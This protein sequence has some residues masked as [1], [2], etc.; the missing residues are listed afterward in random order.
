MT[1]SGDGGGDDSFKP[2][3]LL[4][5]FG[6]QRQTFFIVAARL[7]ARLPA[8]L[9]GRR[10]FFAREAASSAQSAPS[11]VARPVLAGRPLRASRAR[12]AK[13]KRPVGRLDSLCAQLAGGR[14]GQH[15]SR[16]HLAQ[17]CA[18]FGA[19]GFGC[20]RSS[21]RASASEYKEVCFSNNLGPRTSAR[22]RRRRRQLLIV[23]Q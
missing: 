1:G 10:L 3:C 8:C 4:K 2:L 16:C 12:P 15:S 5:A 13:T 22:R 7:P 6:R 19:I 11:S 21:K 20:L 14:T 23:C 17:K 9:P 18:R